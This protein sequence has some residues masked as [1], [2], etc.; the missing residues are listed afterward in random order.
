MAASPKKQDSIFWAAVE[1]VSPA[2]RAKFLDNACSENP[3]QR[4]ELEEMLTAYPKAK[5]FLEE[6][7]VAA[8]DAK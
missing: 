7:L 6:P 3:R 1:I 5:Q 2:K 4:A 8:I